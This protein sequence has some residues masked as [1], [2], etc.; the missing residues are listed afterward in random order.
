M[1]KNILIGAVIAMI[2]FLWFFGDRGTIKETETI[3]EY[4]TTYIE[5][6]HT[7]TIVLTKTVN[8][9]VKL[10]SDTVHDTAFV[11]RDYYTMKFHSDTIINDSLYKVVVN[12][13]IYKN[14]IV[15][16]DVW[17][18]F[19]LPEI[20]KTVTKHHYHDGI[21]VVGHIGNYGYGVGG[22]YVSNR[23]Q[24]G[25]HYDIKNKNVFGS[26]GYRIYQR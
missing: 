24:Y 10:P 12:D 2:L 8:H 5:V 17:Y 6:N 15:H 25:L 7:D 23:W 13:S 14:D 1:Y 19:N 26:I 18:K 9:Y 4:D 22:S 16:R 3:T 20:T 11:Y 21:Y